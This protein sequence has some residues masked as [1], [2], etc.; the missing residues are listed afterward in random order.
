MKYDV[1]EKMYCRITVDNT[2]EVKNLFFQKIF[3]VMVISQKL[4]F[5]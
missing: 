4:Y 2:V 1:R 3:E 5:V